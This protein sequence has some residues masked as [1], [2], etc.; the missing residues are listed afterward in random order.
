MSTPGRWWPRRLQHLARFSAD[1]GQGGA[2]FA[3]HSGSAEVAE[4]ADALNEASLTLRAQMGTI[5]SAE[6]RTQTILDA[7]GR[8]T[9]VNPSIS[10]IFGLEPEQALNHALDDLPPGLDAAAIEASTLGGLFMRSR[11]THTVR[12]EATA[13]RL[14]A[15]PSRWRCRCRAPTRPRACVMPPWCA[16]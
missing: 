12:F 11:G 14:G 2:L 3:Q 13:R 4:L 16:T 6:A 10:S 9:T 7:D 15:R 5:C 1:I 8:I